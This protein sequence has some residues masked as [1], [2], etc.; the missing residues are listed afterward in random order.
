MLT[1]ILLFIVAFVILQIGLYI[2]EPIV[3]IPVTCIAIALGISSCNIG[4]NNLEDW[5]IV[6]AHPP[7]QECPATPSQQEQDLS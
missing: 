4:V 7:V 1:S 6:V 5:I 2:D 3:R